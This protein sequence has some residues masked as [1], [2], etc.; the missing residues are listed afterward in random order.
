VPWQFVLKDGRRVTGV[1]VEE[2]NGT[3]QVGESTGVITKLKLAEIDR[4]I[5]QKGS[6]MPDKL[7]D[8]LTQHELNDLIAFLMNNGGEAK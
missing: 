8:A 7:V 2:N 4:R 6:V 5:L 3:V 1:I